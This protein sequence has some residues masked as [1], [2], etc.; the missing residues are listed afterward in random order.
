MR[1]TNVRWMVFAL[2][3][4]TSWLLYLHRYS[5]AL[6]KPELVREWG[7]GATELGLLDSAFST[8]YMIF[9]LPAGIMADLAGARLV[10]TALILIWSVAFALHAWAPG[11]PALWW[12]RT[13]L[14]LGQAG[15]FAAVSRITRLWFPIGVRATVQGFVGVF[16][17][18]TGGLSAYLLIGYLMVGLLG[19]NWRHAIYVWAFVGLLQ[20]LALLLLY[21]N[22]P[23]RHPWANEAEVALIEGN[24]KIVPASTPAV[25]PP[26]RSFFSAL[27]SMSPRSAIN[28]LALNV[29]SILSTV[30]DNLYSNW[31]PL[32]LFQVH[33]LKFKEMGI[34]SALPLLGGALGGAL[35]GW[36]NDALLSRTGNR[37]WSR[38]GIAMTGKGL[39]AICLVVAVVTT[40]DNPYAFCWMLFLVKFVGDW[41]LSTMWATVTDIGGPATAS[42]FAWNNTVASIGAILAPAMYGFVAEWYNWKLVFIIASVAYG[43]CALSWLAVNC[44]IPL[45]A[46]DSKGDSP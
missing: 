46:E 24:S 16:A 21:R 19:M 23:R 1:P 45:L 8:S 34:Y 33:G 9:Q 12:A 40:Y 44:T 30:A 38:S 35:G 18:R 37:R 22:S 25:A 27:R 5:F 11:M 43:L 4:G 10:L 29:Q 41:S 28:L 14:G 17:A 6:I 26:K 39:A 20:A 36:L 32:F 42:V 2:C 7:V 15:V 13:F 3:G 31:I